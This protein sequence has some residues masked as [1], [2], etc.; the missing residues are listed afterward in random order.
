M[1][2][3][4]LKIFW[5]CG[6]VVITQILHSI[7]L[8]DVPRSLGGDGDKIS[9]L[10]L[11]YLK[12]AFAK[13]SYDEKSKEFHEFLESSLERFEMKKLYESKYLLKESD[14]RHWLSYR[15]IYSEKGYAIQL[16]N[17]PVEKIFSP[18]FGDFGAEFSLKPVPVEKYRGTTYNA[19]ADILTN[20]GILN[21][22]HAFKILDSLIGYL[23]ENNLLKLNARKTEFFENIT[24][25]NSRKA[26]D[27]LMISYPSLGVTLNNYFKVES[28]FSV[29]A[30]QKYTIFKFRGRVGPKL[31]LAYPEVGYWLDDLKNLGHV[32]GK[33]L[34]TNGDVLCKFYV[35]SKTE[36]AYLEFLSKDGFVLG[37]DA[38]GNPTGSKFRFNDASN[39][40]FKVVLDMDINVYVIQLD[41]DL[42]EVNGNLKQTRTDMSLDL[43]IAKIERFRV[44]GGF[45]YVIP[46]WAI[47]W[48]IPSNLEEI[49]HEFTKTLTE[50]NDGK[51][52]QIALQVSNDSSGN[53]LKTSLNINILDN[54]FVRFGLN[55]W[56][57][58]FLPSDDAKE[59]LRNLSN[60]LIGKLIKELESK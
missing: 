18:N 39:F 24:D 31:K 40:R 46:Y 8:R 17:K 19:K 32:S 2:H 34:N 28:L 22:G 43:F 35:E 29:D 47:N 58:R 6:L 4:T 20:F 13:A 30:N 11:K 57:R 45:L 21:H 33:I 3:K 7:T 25:P 23:D 60:E 54:F 51:G 1:K 52:S 41:N 9:I 14:G 55:I 59:Q 37:T 42:I 44:T 10:F 56:N 38:K 15:G 53:F 50:A 48:V 36:E 5:V 26:I 16:F 12:S 49:I 27:D